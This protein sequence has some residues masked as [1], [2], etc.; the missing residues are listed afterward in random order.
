MSKSPNKQHIAK[1]A[2][3]GDIR[4]GPSFYKLELNGGMLENH[5]FGETHQWSPCSQYLALEE[6]LTTDYQQDP[7]T[8]LFIIDAVSGKF[9]AAEPIEKGF[10][11]TIEFDGEAIKYSKRYSAKNA[12]VDSVFSLSGAE[13]WSDL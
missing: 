8:R 12:L 5:I 1:F 10:V 13:P 6:W 11:D 9:C 3:E 4:F 2:H 7:H